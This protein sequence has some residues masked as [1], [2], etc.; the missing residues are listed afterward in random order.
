MDF[1]SLRIFYVNGLIT[2]WI[3]IKNFYFHIIPVTGILILFMKEVRLLNE[4]HQF[5]RKVSYV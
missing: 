1:D 3:L 5:R 4:I 2:I